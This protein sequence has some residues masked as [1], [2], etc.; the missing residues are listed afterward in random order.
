MMKKLLMTVAIFLSLSTFADDVTIS[1]GSSVR[2]GYTT[3]YCSGGT[4]PHVMVDCYCKSG[5]GPWGG[6]ELYKKITNLETGAVISDS[7]IEQFDGT[8]GGERE[9]KEAPKTDPRCY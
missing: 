9:C 7:K 4:A 5:N 8:W 2:V 3:V 6:Y 1:P